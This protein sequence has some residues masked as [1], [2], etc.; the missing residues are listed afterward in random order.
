MRVEL[1]FDDGGMNL[2]SS[3]ALRLIQE[4]LSVISRRFSESPRPGETAQTTDNRQPT[5]DN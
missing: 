5:T 4:S 2:L 1:V 3:S